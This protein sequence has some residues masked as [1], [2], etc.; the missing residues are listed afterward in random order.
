MKQ[1]AKRIRAIAQL[2]KYNRYRLEV[3]VIF[4]WKDAQG[5]RQQVVGLAHGVSVRGAFILAT[6]P[7]PLNAKV[8]LKIYLPPIGAARPRRI[9][10]R[11]KVVRVGGGPREASRKLRGCGGVLIKAV[12][13]GQ[14]SVVSQGW[15]PAS[16]IIFGFAP[17]RGEP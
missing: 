3:P 4:S 2:R 17:R 10:G 13:S 5:V 14:S 7:P 1:P 6:R 16:Y 15:R 11:G 12:V 9:C 8:E